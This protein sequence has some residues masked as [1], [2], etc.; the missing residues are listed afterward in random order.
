MMEISDVLL[1]GV[2]ELDPSLGIAYHGWE[3]AEAGVWA[4]ASLVASGDPRCC[5][6]KKRSMVKAT[7]KGDGA[8]RVIINTDCGFNGNPMA[9]G[10]FCG[11]LVLILMRHGPV[12][13]WIQQGWLGGVV[14]ATLDGKPSSGVTLFKLDFTG[15][16]E[17]SQLAF[18]VGHPYK[19]SPYSHCV[20]WGIGR[21]H[22]AT[23][24]YPELPCDLYVRGDQ[25]ISEM[26]PEDD[27]SLI[28]KALSDFKK[29]S[30]FNSANNKEAKKAVTSWLAKRCRTIIYGEEAQSV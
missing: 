11:A 28:F 15:G 18:W 20:N 14:D 3:T 4:E 16:F 25:M 6:R 30:D 17:P 1:T 8:Y 21:D 29:A 2:L 9:L 24:E 27:A 23:S 10:G 13:I 12:E 5:V 26:V 7:P 19:D 22:T